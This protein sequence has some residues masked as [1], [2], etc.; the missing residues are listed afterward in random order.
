MLYLSFP[1]LPPQALSNWIPA[2]AARD[3]IAG[4]DKM[5]LSFC[6]LIAMR[7]FWRCTVQFMENHGATDDSGQMALAELSI[8]EEQS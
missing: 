8:K 4:R 2:W 6:T 3:S 1:S 7:Y 5:I